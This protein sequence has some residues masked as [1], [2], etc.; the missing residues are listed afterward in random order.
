MKII[1]LYAENIKRL[2]AVEITPD[3]VMQIVSGR[4]GQGKTSILDSIWLALQYRKASLDNPSPVRH[5]TSHGSVQLDLGEYVVTRTFNQKDDGEVTTSLKL[6]TANGD[7]VKKPQQILD[8][9]IGDLS[10]DPLE[11]SR[12][13]ESDQRTI[14]SDLVFKTTGINLN[15]FDAK[16]KDAFSKRTEVNREK[17]RLEGLLTGLKPPDVNDPKEEENLT[18]LI[19]QLRSTEYALTAK[20]ERDQKINELKDKW[21]RLSDELEETKLALDKLTILPQITVTQE[22]RDLLDKKIANIGK[23]NEKARNNKQYNNILKELQLQEKESE[24]LSA[25][26]ELNEIEKDE[27]LEAAKLPISGLKITESGVLFDGV[28]FKQLSG[29]QKLKVSLSLAMASNPSLRVIRI[30]DGSLLDS[31]NLEIIKEMAQEKDFQ[32]WI[33][34]VDDTKKMGV[35]IE[36]GT[37]V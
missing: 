30:T 18:D 10:F 4:N 26:I 22:D 11:F 29:A 32:V 16:I 8:G 34:M 15:E 21:K 1:K 19:N 17:K 12:K 25:V 13:N 14:L 9:I 37:V 27:A 24:K 31:A 7:I 6:E 35:Y 5:G 3:G 23:L 2:K 20:Y 28:P 36:D 33:E